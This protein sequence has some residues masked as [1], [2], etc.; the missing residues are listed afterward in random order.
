MPL[1]TICAVQLIFNTLNIIVDSSLS[2][3]DLGEPL[4]LVTLVPT[5][6]I[7]SLI[8]L[9]LL[10]LIAIFKRHQ[11]PPSSEGP[12]GSTHKLPRKMPFCPQDIPCLKACVVAL[13]VAVMIYTP[14]LFNQ[15]RSLHYP[16]N[17]HH[18]EIPH[19]PAQSCYL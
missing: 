17:A 19:G 13:D 14:Q 2:R 6:V 15:Q 4:R 10:G 1:T 12:T 3:I 7:V 11:F 8:L 18:Q 9:P 16:L 5:M